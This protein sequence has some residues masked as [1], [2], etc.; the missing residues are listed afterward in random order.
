MNFAG[1]TDSFETLFGTPSA[2]AKCRGVSRIEHGLCLSCLLQMAFTEDEADAEEDFVSILHSIAVSDTHWRLGNYEILEEIGRGGM[3]V[4]YRAKQRH[5]RRVVALKRVLGYQNH[6]RETL[7]RFRREA[8]AAASLDHPNILPIYEIGEDEGTPYFSMKF[9]PGGSLQEI[10]PGL[11]DNPREIARVMAKVARAVDYAHRRGILHRDLKPGNILLDG[12]GEPLVTDFG[13]AKW[14]DAS[15]DLTQ[16]LTIFGTPGFI[17]PE[18]AD[19]APSSLGPA[20]DVYSLGAILFCL[21]AGR[22]PF[23]G[24]HALAVIRQAAVKPAPS[25]R[26]LVRNGDRD[27]DTI[28][29]RCLEREPAVRYRSAGDLADDLERWLGG[30]TIVARPV[31]FGIHMWRWARRSP[32]LASAAAAVIFLAGTLFVVQEKRQHLRKALN[33]ETTY[34]R[35]VTVLPVLDLDE[36]AIDQKFTKS[37]L[38]ALEIEV[39][40]FG[41]SRIL[42]VADSR[43]LFPGAGTPS[44]L[45]AITSGASTRTALMG[46]VRKVGERLCVVLRLVD[47]NADK[48]LWQRRFILDKSASSALNLAALAAGEL[49]E[50]LDGEDLGEK[51][52]PDPVLSNPIASEEFRSGQYFERLLTPNDLDIA[53]SSYRKAID[54][55]P[56]SALARGNFAIVAVNRSMIDKMGPRSPDPSLMAK[57]ESF[58]KEAVPAR[59]CHRKNPS[60]LGLCLPC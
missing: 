57:A 11:R 29:A 49:S 47:P 23:L 17:A 18:Q 21:L 41:P 54:S 10:G 32:T 36:A 56:K 15:N 12:W 25:L 14:L 30:R 35:S 7:V 48:P 3:G 46:T 51:S 34:R 6:L 20:A 1:L 50:T 53:L 24:E 31:S 59:I 58:G 22:P 55:A 19:G 27:L 9:A 37:L 42:P 13:L 16:S 8:E 43:F 5:S 28:C 38:G 52:S 26:S 4:I 40:R 44:D 45:R 2:C 60:G 33:A 39:P